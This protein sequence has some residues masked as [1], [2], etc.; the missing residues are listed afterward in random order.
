[1]MFDL[2]ELHDESTM[3]LPYRSRRELLASLRLE[4]PWWRTPDVFEDGQALYNAVCQHGLEGVVAKRLDGRYQPGE[5]GWVKVK[6]PAYWRR[7]SE[8]AGFG[9]GA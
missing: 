2:L 6:N 8:L 4:G 9:R 3:D 1:M 5:R 7:E